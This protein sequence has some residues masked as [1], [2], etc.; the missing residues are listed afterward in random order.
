MQDYTDQNN[1]ESLTDLI[2]KSTMLFKKGKPSILAVKTLVK[3]I[4][5]LFGKNKT[6]EA[7]EGK[8][9]IT[10]QDMEDLLAII[11]NI[12]TSVKKLQKGLEKVKKVSE[13]TKKT[14]IFKKGGANIEGH[15][16]NLTQNYE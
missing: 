5:P 7:L 4:K 15:I 13:T 3:A 8:N 2:E 6:I 14:I 16:K 10:S 9:D 1:L 11:E 12:Y